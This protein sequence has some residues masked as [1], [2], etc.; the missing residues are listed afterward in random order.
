MEALKSTRGGHR[1]G[2]GRKS[3]YPGKHA[4]LTVSVTPETAL[5]ARALAS[6]MGTTVSD[7][8]EAAIRAFDSRC[9]PKASRANNEHAN[10]DAGTSESTPKNT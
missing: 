5:K 8:V 1:D 6:A 3:L 9:A 7:A 10:A 2:A 4:K